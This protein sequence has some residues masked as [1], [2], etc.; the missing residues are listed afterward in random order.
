MSWTTLKDTA[1]K[2]SG[3]YYKLEDGDNKLRIVSQATVGGKHWINNKASWCLG[4]DSGCEGCAKEDPKARYLFH[5]IDRKDG[6]IKIAEFGWSIVEAIIGFQ[7]S[8]DYGFPADGLPPYDITINKKGQK[9]DTE[10][11]VLPARQNTLLTP[12]EQSEVEALKP[13]SEFV[14]A[15]KGK[16]GKDAD[17]KSIPF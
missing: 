14:E 7:E 10:Y 3:D 15:M 13:L 9:L 11:A 6:K 16:A 5:V 2:A 12:D 1:P 17:L 4:K 8:E